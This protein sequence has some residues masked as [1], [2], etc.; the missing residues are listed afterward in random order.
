M[1]IKVFGIWLMAANINTL[2]ASGN[3]CL[4]YGNGSY[5]RVYFKNH[6]CDQVAEEINN[7]LKATHD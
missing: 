7:Q 3:S 6:T 1:L 2:D 4:A 5:A